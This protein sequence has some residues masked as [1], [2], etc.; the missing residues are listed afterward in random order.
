MQTKLSL[1][2]MT[3]EEKIRL[4]EEIW[5]DLI[6]SE[7]NY[8]SP[9]WH[10]DVLILREKRVKEGKENYKDWEIAKK[11]LRKNLNEN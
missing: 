6:K 8:P 10:L 1:N 7:D 2:E 4:M 5:I 3:I 9:D 11:E